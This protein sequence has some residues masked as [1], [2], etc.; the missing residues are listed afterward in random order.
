VAKVTGMGVRRFDQA[1]DVADFVATVFLEVLRSAHGFDPR[2][3]DAVA[4]LYGLAGH[5]A[6]GMYHRRAR[7]A[8]A[9]QRLQ[10]RMFLDADD[11]VRVEERIDAAVQLRRTYAAMQ[12]LREGDRRVLELVA[13]DGLSPAEVAQALSISPVTARVRLTRARSRL[14]ALLAADDQPDPAA[15]ILMNNPTSKVRKEPA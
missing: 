2:R 6:A 15:K 5:V 7:T 11:Y 10:G 14:R 1:E 3:G 8:E 12:V 4:W 9:E 13:L